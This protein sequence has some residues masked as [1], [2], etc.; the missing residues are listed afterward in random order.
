[1]RALIWLL[2]RW[3]W[4][5]SLAELELRIA[6]E[7]NLRAQCAVAGQASPHQLFARRRRRPR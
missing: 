6:A 7:L 3:P 2:I 4:T 1:M 5:V